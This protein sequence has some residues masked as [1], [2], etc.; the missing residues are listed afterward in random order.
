MVGHIL[1]CVELK[2]NIHVVTHTVTGALAQTWDRL[3]QAGFS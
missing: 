1:Q 3:G 2:V